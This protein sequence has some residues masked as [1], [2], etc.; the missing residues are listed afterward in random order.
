MTDAGHTFNPD[1]P[2]I[3]QITVQGY[4]DARRADWFDG[5]VIKPQVDAKG[6]SVTRLTGEVVDQ[7]AL[8]GLLRKLYD[9]G[10]SLLSIKRIELD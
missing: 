7:A 1:C 9:L 8:H 3:Y 6:M 4:L 2:V 10:L 5:M